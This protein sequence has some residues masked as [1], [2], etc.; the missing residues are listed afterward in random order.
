MSNKE[1]LECFR[2]CK[3][4]RET[5]DKKELKSWLRKLKHE[6]IIEIKDA[7]YPTEIMIMRALMMLLDEKP[8]ENV[9]K[10]LLTIDFPVYI[11]SYV[12]LLL[13]TT[14]PNGNHAWDNT[15]SVEEVD[16]LMIKFEKALECCKSEDYWDSCIH[17]ACEF[18]CL[19]LLEIWAQRGRINSEMIEFA[20]TKKHQKLIDHCSHS[21]LYKQRIVTEKLATDKFIAAMKDESVEVLH[22]VILKLQQLEKQKRILKQPRN[23]TPKEVD[24]VATHLAS[25]ITMSDREYT[26]MFVNLY[27]ES[28]GIP[29][30][31]LSNVLQNS[32][33]N[34]SREH[35]LKEL[36]A[37][38]LLRDFIE[39]CLNGRMK[40]LRKIAH[41]DVC[42][43]IFREIFNELPEKRSKLESIMF[44]NIIILLPSL[45]SK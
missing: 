1:V 43:K 45:L 5:G 40:T 6:A 24:R 7:A 42:E 20:L 39:Y 16:Q 18:N 13:R 31:H 29:K 27:V 37:N 44:S 38:N 17:I 9:M 8:R 23:M 3:L 32:L 21:D 2:L 30:E 35:I 15:F 28:Q 26:V 34:V 14:I 19:K 10:Y 41:H 33:S 25:K 36:N 4:F 11:E 12:Y 22:D